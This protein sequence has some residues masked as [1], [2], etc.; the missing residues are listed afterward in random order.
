[1]N[2]MSHTIYNDV[3]SSVLKQLRPKKPGSRLSDMGS[4]KNLPNNSGND[5]KD[6]ID[7]ETRSNNKHRRILQSAT[8]VQ[9]IDRRP[10]YAQELM[11]SKVSVDPTAVSGT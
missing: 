9:R 5:L 10:K 8:R 11:I 1:M 4:Y 6:V 3:L 7:I 2:G